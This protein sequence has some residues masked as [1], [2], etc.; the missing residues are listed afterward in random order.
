MAHSIT[1]SGKV[2]MLA[3]LDPTRFWGPVLYEKGTYTPLPEYPGDLQTIWGSMNDA[4]VMA[5][6]SLTTSFGSRAVLAFPKAK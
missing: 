2:L 5:G 3:P 4:G 6:Q 1:N